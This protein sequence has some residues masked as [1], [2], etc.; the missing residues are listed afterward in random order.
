MGTL[1]RSYARVSNK[2]FLVQS[3]VLLSN[4]FAILKNASAD[5]NDSQTLDIFLSVPLTFSS[6][7]FDTMVNITFASAASVPNLNW[8]VP[9]GN[10]TKKRDPYAPIPANP[11]LESYLDR[12]LSVYN[13]SDKILF[14]SMLEDSVDKDL[15]ER[16]SG[17]ELALENPDF[18]QGHVYDM[19][20]FMQIVDAYEKVTLDMQV[21]KIPWEKLIGFTADGLDLNRISPEAL[22]FLAPEIPPESIAKFTSERTQDYQSLDDLPLERETKEKLKKLK[23]VFYSPKVSGDILIGNGERK[24]HVAFMYDLGSKKVSD[25]EITQ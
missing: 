15:N 20:H 9:D 25:I 11:V 23:V 16:V 17:S 19:A 8:L 24:L 4:M 3:D 14:L 2:R 5:V 6:K 21:R 12:I 18:T 10:G 7:A 1:D 22:A 13:V